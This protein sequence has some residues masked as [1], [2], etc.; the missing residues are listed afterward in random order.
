MDDDDLAGLMA[1]V[2]AFRFP[3]QGKKRGRAPMRALPSPR[4]ASQNARAQ[5]LQRAE[6]DLIPDVPGAPARDAALLPVAWPVF[7]FALATGTNII[8]LPMNPQTA[9]RGRR[10]VATVLRNGAS[11]ALTAPVITLLQVGMKPILATPDGVPLEALAQTGFDN[12]LLF[13]PTTPG[14][15]YTLGLRL[16]I[17]LTGTDTITVIVGLTGSAVL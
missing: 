9:F 14:T 17:A 16:P 15:L 8:Q 2:G 13:P 5:R 3:W 12:N 1:E 11:A 6:Q 7:S 4:A 10:I